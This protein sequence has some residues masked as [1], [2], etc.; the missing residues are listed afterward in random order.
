M[1]NSMKLGIAINDETKITTATNASLR[2]YM[3]GASASIGG[4][5]GQ[6]DGNAANRLFRI[7]ATSLSFS[8]DAAF[9][10]VIY[11]PNASQILGGGGENNFD[12]MDRGDQNRHNGG[13]SI[14][15]SI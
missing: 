10:G 4:K 6:S 15:M 14:T 3:R 9:T 7:Y 1:Q 2:I 11:A 13:T 8:A 12:F 5:G